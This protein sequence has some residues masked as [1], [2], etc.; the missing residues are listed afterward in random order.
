MSYVD[1]IDYGDQS[2]HGDE[3]DL[4]QG[5]CRVYGYVRENLHMTLGENHVHQWFTQEELHHLLGE[6]ASVCQAIR[7]WKRTD[8]V[9]GVGKAI[10][11][12]KRQFDQG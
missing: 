1:D 12:S 10:S 2:A 4:A 6:S 7:Q 11:Q 9:R 5:V 3:I 8:L